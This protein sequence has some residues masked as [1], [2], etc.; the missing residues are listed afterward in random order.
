VYHDASQELGSGRFLLSL[1]FL[2]V[3]YGGSLL[4]F[5]SMV[6]SFW[7]ETKRRHA[8]ALLLET[9]FQQ[10]QHQIR[11]HFLFNTLNTIA[12]LY[13]KEE[14]QQ[15]RALVLKLAL[16]FRKLVNLSEPW[17]SLEETLSQTRLYLEIEQARF[18]GKIHF[19]IDAQIETPLSE[20]R[21]PILSIQPLVEN[22]VKH[23]LRDKR[24]PGKI[25]VSILENRDSVEVKVSDD[26]VGMPSDF[27][28]I[29]SSRR[30]SKA[31]HAGVG[32]Q[33]IHGRLM[34]LGVSG[35]LKIQSE[36]EKGTEVSFSLPRSLAC[37]EAQLRKEDG[38]R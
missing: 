20:I 12:G 18:P 26:G 16:L 6:Y 10:L 29:L 9:R 37:A 2:V 13:K 22:A 25:V 15:A 38:R 1:G 24:G 5:F 14:A 28:D 33:N 30:A 32:L 34:H 8:E 17:M 27:K 23:G 4:L 36:P 11:P 35:G 21:V 3:L 7:G 31:D 19:Q